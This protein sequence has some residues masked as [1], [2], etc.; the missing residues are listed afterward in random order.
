MVTPETDD[1]GAPHT[2]FKAG[3]GFH[4]FHE[5]QA[6]FP[7]GLIDD[8]VDKLEYAIGSFSR[9]VFRANSSFHPFA[10][11]IFLKPNYG[12]IPNMQKNPHSSFQ[13]WGVWLLRCA[14]YF[15]AF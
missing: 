14:D 6:V 1:T 12:L 10:T 4:D 3:F 2:G 11:L 9:F 13:E 15:L 8:G 5:A 7:L